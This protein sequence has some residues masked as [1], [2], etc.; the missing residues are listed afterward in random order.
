MM[1]FRFFR[2]PTGA[3]A[4]CGFCDGRGWIGT[5][6]VRLCPCCLG[7]CRLTDKFIPKP[8]RRAY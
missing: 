4:R 3:R 5:H 7:V 2:S 8:K 6:T 1:A